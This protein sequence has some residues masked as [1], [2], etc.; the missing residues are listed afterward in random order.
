[1]TILA[2]GH[3]ILRLSLCALFDLAL[4]ASPAHAQSEQAA[5]SDANPPT[6]AVNQAALDARLDVNWHQLPKNFVR[7]Q[8]DMWLLYPEQIGKGQHLLPTAI[9]TGITAALFASDP[10][11][12]QSFRDIGGANGTDGIIGSKTSG[13]LIAAVPSLFYV[14]GLAR[15]NQYDQAT[16]LFA[17][18]VVVDDTIL[19][20]VLKA[21]TRRERP[22]DRPN[23]GPYN[24]TFFK[25]SAGPLGK[26]SGFPSGHAMMSFSIATVF[27]RRYKQ[28]KWLPYVAYAAATAIT[29]SRVTTG[30]HFPSEA[31]IG[32]TTGYAIA[33]YGVLH[34]N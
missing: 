31:F 30:A 32:A 4:I 8:K 34:G 23:G 33:R 1:M 6:P 5:A 19:M 21:I 16:S 29:F 24:D 15:H 28:H 14:V 12:I 18:E 22:L 7:D 9:V 25:S 2:G 20:I 3:G 11:T 27:A 26:G 10:H 13:A 17:G